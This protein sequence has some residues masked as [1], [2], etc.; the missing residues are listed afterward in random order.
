M[1]LPGKHIP[2]VKDEELVKDQP[3][4][5]V[6]LA[7]HYGKPIA[8]ILRDQMGLKSKLV[9]PLPAVTIWEGDIPD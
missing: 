8:R 6:I 9:L 3:D 7:W 5:I 2:V 1:L 4:Y